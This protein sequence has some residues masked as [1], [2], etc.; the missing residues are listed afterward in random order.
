MRRALLL[1]CALAALACARGAPAAGSPPAA[2]AVAADTLRGTLEVVGSAP[3]TSLALLLDG[4]ARAV[5]LQGERPLLDGLSGLEV[6]V[7][8]ALIRPGV[9]QV[10]RVAVRA[11]GG[12]AAVDGVLL[13]EGAGWV[14][15]TGDGRR[16]PVPHLPATL[17][18]ME[19]ARIWLAGP[20]DRPPDSFGIIAPP[21]GAARRT[22]DTLQV[23]R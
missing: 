11:S 10:D 20:L 15:A 21:P 4:G 5:A 19:G 23:P 22:G 12:V 3:A 6:A 1:P 2:A 8:G 9:F 13:R 7:W 18:A 16:L 17:R 14:V